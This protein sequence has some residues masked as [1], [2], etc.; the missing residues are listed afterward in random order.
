VQ[1]QVLAIA[2]S[3][4]SSLL[5]FKASAQNF[6]AF[7]IFG[8]S[9]VD[10]G[11]L[12][13]VTG[14]RIPP[15]PPYFNGRFSNGPVWVEL[16]APKLGISASAFNDFAFGGATTGTFNALSPLVGVP[17]PGGLALQINGFTSAPGTA[18]PNGLYVVWAGANDY[19]VLPPQLRTTDTTA[20]VNNLAGALTALSAKGAN[21]FLVVNLPDLGQTPQERVLPTSAALTAVTNNHNSQLTAALQSL[22]QNRN[23]NIIPLDANAL[24]KEVLAEPARYGFTNVTDRCFNQATGTLCPNPDQHLFWDGI[25]PSAAGHRLIAE[26]AAAVLT[27]PQTIAPQT[28]IALNVA[29]RP[30]QNINARLVSLRS[31]PETSSNQRVGVFINGDV[32]FG[33][34]ESRATKPGFDFTTTGVTAGVDYRVTNNFALGV[35]VGYVNN[36]TDLNNNLGNIDIDG[37]NVSAYGNYVQNNFY[38]D[39]V[40]SYG[41]NN[42]D[43]QRTIAVGN[44][45]ATASPDGNQLSVDVNSGYNFKSGNFSIG[46]AVGVRYARINI[47]GYTE[48]DAGSLNMVVQDQDADSVVLSAGAQA[49]VA[50]KAGTSEVIP[51]VRASYER[52]L[53][54]D[55]REIVTELVTQPGIPM[56]TITNKPDRDY[57]KLGAGTQVVFSEKVSGVIEYQAIVGRKDY[58]DQAVRAEI[59]YQF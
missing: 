52:E 19:L 24:F 13:G 29:R 26:Y 33:D 15:S 38:T 46:P 4:L 31:V 49:S 39:A 41:W 3:V 40:V 34:K 55:R 44:R 27:A 53:A 30:V 14:G 20:V 1:K 32:N 16:L 42:Y 58:S 43:I 50:I 23:I 28:E 12:F 22:A 18:N 25:H 45:T 10:N 7:Y 2:F 47:D 6:D 35:A 54:D 51:Y 59:R 48:K 11:N 37:Y 9:L 56:R 36:S 17:L 5:P 8:D 21:N 57:L